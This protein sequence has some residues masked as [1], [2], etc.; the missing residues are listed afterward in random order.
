MMR[1]H[2]R[3]RRS[4]RTRWRFFP[5]V[6]VPVLFVAFALLLPRRSPSGR[7][8]STSSRLSPSSLSPREEEANHPP[9]LWQS[10]SKGAIHKI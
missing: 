2:A 10:A 7:H 9:P 6:P 8:S 1:L 3:L 4:R 5:P